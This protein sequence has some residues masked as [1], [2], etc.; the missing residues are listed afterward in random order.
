[1]D[2]KFVN[3]VGNEKRNVEDYLLE[4]FCPMATDFSREEKQEVC[5]FLSSI[6]ER[7]YTCNFV[8]S[9][10]AWA[11]FALW[12]CGISIQQRRFPIRYRSGS[13]VDGQVQYDHQWIKWAYFAAYHYSGRLRR[14]EDL[15]DFF[16]SCSQD[17]KI[18]RSSTFFDGATATLGVPREYID[19]LKSE[20]PLPEGWRFRPIVDGVS[21]FS[22]GKKGVSSNNNQC[23]FWTVGYIPED[24]RWWMSVVN[25]QV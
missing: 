3:K 2:W 23:E 25:T 19:A 22:F 9:A 13:V 12:R 20:D 14:W 5:E 11:V 1:V 7:I 6:P 10:S 8:T 15:G 18:T 4:V 21:P 16:F 17:G 24:D